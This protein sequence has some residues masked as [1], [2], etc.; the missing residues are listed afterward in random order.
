MA[1]PFSYHPGQYI[2][3]DKNHPSFS[4]GVTTIDLGG[5]ENTYA[6]KEEQILESATTTN[7]DP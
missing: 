2:V 6:Q 7:R 4:G 1:T 3:E 5:T